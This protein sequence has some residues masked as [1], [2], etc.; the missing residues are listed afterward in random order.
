MIID[1]IN[2]LLLFDAGQHVSNSEHNAL[3]TLHTGEW[4]G[5]FHVIILVS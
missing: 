2:A 5:L 1:I 4:V 3:P